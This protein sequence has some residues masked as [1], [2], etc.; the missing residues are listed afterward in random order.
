VKQLRTVLRFCITLNLIELS[1]K[2]TIPSKIHSNKYKSHLWKRSNKGLQVKSQKK[3]LIIGDSHVRGLTSEL[4][5]NLGHEYSISSTFMPGAGL[6]N[7]TKLA[8]SEVSTLTNSDTI[9]YVVAQI[10]LTETCNNSDL[11]N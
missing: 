11:I 9:I 10:M 3:I 1:D 6:Q 5:N 7:I 2:L 8:K 4:K